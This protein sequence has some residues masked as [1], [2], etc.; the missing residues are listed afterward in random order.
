MSEYHFIKW[1]H[2]DALNPQ[3]GTAKPSPY[4]RDKSVSYIIK[5]EGIDFKDNLGYRS[6]HVKFKHII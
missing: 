4:F 2:G 1:L 6:I 5:K 3:D